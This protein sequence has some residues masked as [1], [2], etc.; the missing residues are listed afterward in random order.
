MAEGKG[1]EPSVACATH[2]FQACSFDRSDTP[3]S[4]AGGQ[5][6]EPWVA[7]ATTVFKT[8]AFDHSAIPR[9]IRQ[10][11]SSFGGDTR[12]RT[13][14]QGFAGPCLTTWLCRR[15]KRYEKW[16]RHPELNTG[17]TALRG[18]CLD[19]W[20]CRHAGVV[21]GAG[22]EPARTSVRGILSPLRLPIPP[23]GP[24][25]SIRSTLRKYLLVSKRKIVTNKMERE[26]G[27][28]PATPTLAR[29]CSTPELLPH[30]LG[31][32]L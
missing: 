9:S 14:D 15:K 19:T 16:R 17:I 13:G 24:E 21:P 26:T 2:A 6:F 4:V 7:C 32:V 8:A 5:G 30:L 20:L 1:F 28:E 23:S 18:R 27:F 3:L 10:I 22:L 29:L 12:I 31:R 25:I 11:F